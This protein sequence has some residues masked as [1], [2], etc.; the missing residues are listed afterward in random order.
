MMSIENK[1]SASAIAVSA[2]EIQ[3][4]TKGIHFLK[5]AI[6]FIS[7][8]GNNSVE[9][10][11]Q[12]KLNE[13]KTIS[14]FLRMGNATD[15]FSTW[16]KLRH[17]IT[18]ITGQQDF[19]GKFFDD[20]SLPE[21]IYC[22]MEPVV[23]G[24]EPKAIRYQI[25][26]VALWTQAGGDYKAH[27]ELR[28]A[29][30]IEIAENIEDNERLKSENPKTSEKVNMQLKNAEGEL[31]DKDVLKTL[32]YVVLGLYTDKV[33]EFA[34]KFAEI[35]NSPELKNGEI[36]IDPQQQRNSVGQEVKSY[37]KVI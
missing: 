18:M 28:K 22:K 14:D 7:N 29:K 21:L 8:A 35:L 27:Q 24:Q 26:N 1:Y 33:Q 16:S 23:P 34:N 5:E 31:V 10:K 11:F 32:N 36:E 15:F 2:P 17:V 4:T 3:K 19:L 6:S 9:L 20:K 25:D 12:H 13:N 30:L 37:S